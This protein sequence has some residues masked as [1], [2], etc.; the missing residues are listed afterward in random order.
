MVFSDKKIAIIGGGLGGIAF[1]NAAIYAGFKNIQLYEQAPEFT[2]VGAG[3]NITKNTN[4]VLDAY[5]L[6]EAMRWKSSRDRHVTWNIE[7]SKP[8][9]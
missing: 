5:G 3:V 1:A 8:E 4:V 9:K 7:V 2:E 6:K